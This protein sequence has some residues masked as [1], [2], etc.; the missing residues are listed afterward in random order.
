MSVEGRV[1]LHITPFNPSLL[2]RYVPESLR[3]QA[4]NIS[5]HTIETFPEKGFGYVELPHMEAQKLKKK[6]NGTVLK[7]S[8][9]K[10]EEARPQK[11]RK[12]EEVEPEEPGEDKAARKRSKKDKKEKRKAGEKVISGHELEE[13]RY[14]KR[15]WVEDKTKSKKAKKDGEK[16]GL[17]GKKMRFK[18]VVP[19][20]KSAVDGKKGK[21]KDKDK[22]SKKEVTVK[23]FDKSRKPQDG[24]ARSRKTEL[25]YEEGQGWIQEDGRTVEAEPPNAKRRR[26][27]DTAK[28]SAKKER[29][30]KKS[31]PEPVAD[32]I[33][34]EAPTLDSEPE[35]SNIEVSHASLLTRE[36]WSGDEDSVSSS[37]VS[38]ES[39]PSPSSSED[40]SA[41][42]DAEL[43]AQLA[44]AKSNTVSN[45]NTPAPD[46]TSGAETSQPVGEPKEIHPLEALFKRP[47]QDTEKPK[48]PP[49]D[50]S[51]SFFTPDDHDEADV[52]V[53]I[54]VPQTPRTKEELEWRS[55]RSAAPTPDTAAIGKSFDFSFSKEE[56]DQDEEVRDEPEIPSRAEAKKKGEERGEES[57]FR[58]WFYEN[59]GD[60]NRAWK[61][62]R[63]E[64]RKAG[65]QRENRR[66]RR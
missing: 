22:R 42:S 25:K 13:G 47:S 44:R 10:I 6:L 59:R 9:V 61:K 49:L 41:D 3:S 16:D 60:L 56:E 52:A 2:E 58:K 50:T 26:E 24:G 18:T 11:K 37:S 14:I 51:F 27:R 53:E 62:R 17:E 21:S 36:Q 8:K 63:R 31:A 45:K 12:S 32:P 39:T 55:I 54:K 48:P 33:V 34:E 1:R 65:R 43:D 20:T 38:S 5:F 29:K 40:E 28:D 15:G 23:E 35:D 64:E 57:E 4:S 19:E 7:G 30:S 66:L 46:A